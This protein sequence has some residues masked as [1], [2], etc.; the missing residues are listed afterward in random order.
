MTGV[1]TC[2]LPISKL[3]IPKGAKAGVYS[4]KFIAEMFLCE[5]VLKVC[6][7]EETPGSFELR[8]AQTGPDTPVRLE[9]ARPQR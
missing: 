2:A 3:E 6:Y 1:Q 9:Y 4:V 7:R 5:A 8:V